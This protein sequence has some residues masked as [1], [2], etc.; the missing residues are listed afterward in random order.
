MRPRSG[1]RPLFERIEDEGVR[2]NAAPYDTEQHVAV[3]GLAIR[4]RARI[5]KPHDT[6][7]QFDRPFSSYFLL[8]RSKNRIQRN[9][10][11]RHKNTFQIGSTG[12]SQ[13]RK[14]QAKIHRD[15][16]TKSQFVYG[17]DN[18]IGN[19]G[20]LVLQTSHKTDFLLYSNT[21][22]YKTVFRPT[23]ILVKD[24]NK[25]S[26]RNF[27]FETEASLGTILTAF[28]GG[29]RFSTLDFLKQTGN[30]MIQSSV[31]KKNEFGLNLDVGLGYRYIVHNTLLEGLGLRNTFAEDPYDDVPIDK[32]VLN[33][34]AIERNLFSLDGG[35]SLRWRKTTFFFRENI[36]N[37]EYK[38]RLSNID[39]EDN[40]FTKKILPKDAEDDPNF[41]RNDVVKDQKKF[42]NNKFYGYGTV[43]FCWL[44]E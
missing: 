28:G 33:K 40:R 26:G 13:G 44:I 12:I 27:S 35:I 10:L 8:G 25:Y 37:L 29:F 38:S 11:I 22:R 16:T 24:N 9:G 14:I 2:A 36:H 42:I 31:R 39:F 32:Y 23:N 7:H 15:V 5:A 21:N 6:L 20:R 34:D 41:Y 17:W 1:A 3:G 30:H 19:G 43:G 18:Q 4:R